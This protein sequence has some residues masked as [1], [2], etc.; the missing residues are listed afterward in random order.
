[1]TRPRQRPPDTLLALLGAY[2]LLSCLF[3]WQAWRRETPTIFTDELE[4][5]QLSR[6]I[7]TTGEPAR[8]GVPLGFT[9]LVPW[10]TA[11][12]W[13]IHQVETAYGAIKYYQALVMAAAVFPAYGIARFAV[14][15]PWAVFAAV[16]TIATPALSYAPMLVEEPFAYPAA[17]LA[18]W[19]ILR[20]I[21]RP[22]LLDVALAGGAAFLA[23][24]VRSQLISLAGILGISLLV[25]GWQSARMRRW[26]TTWSRGDWVGAVLLG[27]GGFFFVTAVIGNRSADWAEVTSNW[28]GRILEYGSWA[29]GAFA[30]GVGLLPAIALLAIPFVPARERV[31]PR[32]RAFV[33]VSAAAIVTMA[34]YAALKGAY[35]S[36]VFSSLIVERNLIYLTPLALAALAAVLARGAAPWWALVGS[37]AAV[38]ALVVATP[39]DRGINS[40]PYYEAHGLAILALLNRELAWPIGRIDTALVIAV[41]VATAALVARVLLAGRATAV[42][43]IAIGVAAVTLVWGLTNEIYAEIGEHDLSQRISLNLTD[44]PEWIDDAVG[45]GKVTVLA[46]QVTDAT[47]IWSNEFWNRSITQVWSVEGSA[48]G[49][50]GTVTPDLARPDGT[51][52]PKPGTPYVLAVNGV[53]L[54]GK[55]VA[56][57]SDGS[58]LMWIG[59]EFRLRANEVGVF[60]DGW[61]GR[62]AAYNRFDVS[63]DGPGLARVSLSRETFCPKG[64]EPARPRARAHRDD[65]RRPRQAAGD[66]PGDR[67]GDRLPACLRDARR[68]LPRSA[69]TVA[70]RGRR[71][72]VRAGRGRSPAVRPANAR[73]RRRVRVRTLR[74]LSRSERAERLRV[75]AHE[76]RHPSRVPERVTREPALVDDG[77]VGVCDDRRGHVP[78]LPAGAHGAVLEVDVLDVVPVAR[79]PPAELVEHLA[80]L[81]QEGTEHPVA[82]HGLGR[83]VLEAVVLP[84]G[85]D[86]TD[87]A[88]RCA[89]H[90]R[91][92]HRR[93]PPPR[94]LGRSV[95]PDQP[96]TCD[97]GPRLALEQRL[98]R[99]DS[100]GLRER[101]GRGVEDELARGR[102]RAQVHV[103]GQRE[104]TAVLDHPDASRERA[105]H[106]AGDVRDDD[107]LVDLRQQRRE[108][109]CDLVA[110]AVRDDDGGDPHRPR[111]SR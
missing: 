81:Q 83:G 29:G 89:S 100:T 91:A 63:E 7:A 36:T 49:P 5:T 42:K 19:L 66:R 78:P 61:M 93:E 90:E 24:L 62:S 97:P 96:R 51:L 35:I 26:R 53:E 1:M 44:P 94:R 106:R 12:F 84:L 11:P 45:D 105:R 72:H 31:D 86:A 77:R 17:A 82:P 55:E 18:L 21:V 111:A 9:T 69:Q 108:E 60:S 67:D 107:E 8:R 95:G 46:Q 71:G 14:T 101:V 23:M 76:P 22:R 43:G 30:I 4:M 52:T 28:K 88:Q 41:V 38:L 70:D 79:V 20:A 47:G 33:T 104:R 15:P 99:A 73:R 80:S 27:L 13:W 50:G 2:L 74:R 57:G 87:V 32:M 10:L 64:V 92:A 58:V 103:R 6:S 39:I 68:G 34:W 110:V 75:A 37:G 25:V 56:Q 109:R 40:F 85:V 102:G 65:R 98:Q 16:G 54:A 48:P 3:L 59:N